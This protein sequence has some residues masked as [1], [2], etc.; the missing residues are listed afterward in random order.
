MKS[1][2]GVQICP[3]LGSFCT[4]TD[5]PVWA[6]IIG[7]SNTNPILGFL[8]FANPIN[9]QYRLIGRTL[10]C[11]CSIPNETFSQG[12]FISK[13]VC[14]CGFPNESIL[15]RKKT[16]YPIFALHLFVQTPKSYYRLPQVKHRLPWVTIGYQ[17]LPKVTVICP[18]IHTVSDAFQSD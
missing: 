5:Q 3:N 9:Q 12:T 4:H 18:V 8:S 15:W 14:Y 10:V 17:W 6:F 2:W 11:Y 13:S 1:F 7:R 16:S